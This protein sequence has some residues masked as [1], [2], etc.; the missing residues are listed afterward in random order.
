MGF[1]QHWRTIIGV[2]VVVA[3]DP[4]LHISAFES[5]F[6]DA[7]NLQVDDCDGG[8]LLGGAKRVREGVAC[9]KGLRW[10]EKGGLA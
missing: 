6:A 10:K 8:D 5:H 7:R 2:V 1:Q 3:Y 9:C 4:F